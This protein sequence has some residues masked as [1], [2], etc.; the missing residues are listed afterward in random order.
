MPRD[1]TLLIKYRDASVAE[2]YAGY[3][4]NLAGDAGFDLYFPEDVTFAPRETKIVPLGVFTAMTENNKSKSD[5]RIWMWIAILGTLSLIN[6]W[7][8]LQS[9]IVFLVVMVLKFWLSMMHG[10]YPD[11]AANLMRSG[12]ISYFIYPRSSIAKTKLRLA[13]SV[14]V[15]D[16]G[17]RGEIM[18]AL[19]N[20]SD[21]EY[22]VPRGMRLVQLVAPAGNITRV[23]V[24]ESFDQTVR[25]AGGFGSTNR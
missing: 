25:G 4:P 14:G 19:D 23:T 2:L 22:I 16:S 12:F 1:A 5:D 6:P 24:V 8:V 9:G 11:T 17:Y 20:I 10:N 13:N 3:R 7:L 21:Q 18:A 15:V